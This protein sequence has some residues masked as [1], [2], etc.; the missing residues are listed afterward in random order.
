MDNNI[1]QT[2][3]TIGFP[4]VACIAMAC[5]V[6]HITDQNNKNIEC[7][8]KTHKAEIDSFNTAINNN[9]MAIQKLTDMLAMSRWSNY[10]EDI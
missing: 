3:S 4:I 6:K 1:I 5:H 2:I 8:T 10:K 9:T 7:I